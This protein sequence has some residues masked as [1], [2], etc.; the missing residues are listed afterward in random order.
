MNV[1]RTAYVTTDF[2]KDK[3]LLVHTW[4]P[5]SV[6]MTAEAYKMEVLNYCNCVLEYQAKYVIFDLTEF[7]YT[8]VPE[9]QEWSSENGS[10]PSMRL[11]VKKIAIIVAKDFFA[12]IS[13]EQTVEEHAE[14]SIITRYFR[15]YEEAEA[16]TQE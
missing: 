12:T 3:S 5:A 14:I 6:N 13:V 15:S 16:W 11:G 9:L 7:F 8:I 1:Y 2:F 10:K 4:L